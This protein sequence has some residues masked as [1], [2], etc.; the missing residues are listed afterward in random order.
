MCVCSVCLFALV[1]L[2]LSVRMQ[3]RNNGT[4]DDEVSQL[5]VRDE[6]ASVTAPIKA[7]KGFAR[8]FIR[9]GESVRVQIVL[10]VDSLQLFNAN[11]QMVVEN[12][13][14]TLTVATSSADSDVRLRGTLVVDILARDEMEL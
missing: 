5:Y 14:F 10:N 4:R 9:V 13:D 3:V 6:V 8:T 7:L 12:G 11:E 1:R 2:V